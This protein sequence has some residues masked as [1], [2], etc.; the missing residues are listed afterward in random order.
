MMG[1]QALTTPMEGSTAD[2]IPALTLTPAQPVSLIC[3]RVQKMHRRMKGDL[4]VG[5]ISSSIP[6]RKINRTM[7]AIQTNPPSKNN[8]QTPIFLLLSSCKLHTIGIG[9]ASIKISVNIFPTLVNLANAEKFTQWP[10]GM[11]LSQR[12]ATGVHWNAAPKM[13]M[14]PRM[15]L[16]MKRVKWHA[17]HR[18]V[19][20]CWGKRRR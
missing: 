1:R 10:P 4:Q 16:A 12:Y 3:P 20:V 19:V 15:T 18:A 11:V 8:P 14:M 7:L 17:R 5:S 6:S 2:Q 9:S 13:E